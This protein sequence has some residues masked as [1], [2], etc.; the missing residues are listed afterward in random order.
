MKNKLFAILIITFLFS[1]TKVFATVDYLVVNH[2]TKQLY[3]AATDRSPG[4]IGWE[5]IPEGQQES[6][7]KK[8][9][10]MGYRFTNNPFLIEKIIAI[11][12]ALLLLTYGIVRTIKK[13]KTP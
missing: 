5:P 8:Y 10:K 9:K 12:I 3:W 6:D 1:T 13:E 7:E 2:L 11:T 4:W